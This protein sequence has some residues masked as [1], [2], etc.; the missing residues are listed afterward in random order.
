MGAGVTVLKLRRHGGRSH[1][2]APPVP[3]RVRLRWRVGDEL[4]EAELTA[5]CVGELLTLAVEAMSPPEPDVGGTEDT[6]PKRSASGGARGRPAAKE[7]LEV[8]CSGHEL[9]D[10]QENAALLPTVGRG[11]TEALVAWAVR[12]EERQSWSAAL[13]D[14]FVR[15]S[16]RVLRGAWWRAVAAGDCEECARLLARA[17]P[18]SHGETSD[19]EPGTPALLCLRDANR[20]TAL[21]VAVDCAD[22][23]LCRWLVGVSADTAAACGDGPAPLARCLARVSEAS[24]FERMARFFCLERGA[25][26]EAWASLVPAERCFRAAATGLAWLAEETLRREGLLER[27]AEVVRP[28]WRWTLL[29]DAAVGGSEAVASLVL[30]HAPEL[31]GAADIYRRTP[32]H[33]AA[34]EGHEALLPLLGGAEHA[35][36][37][38]SVDGL[39]RTPLWL[40]A[41]CGRAGCCTWLVARRCDPLRRDGGGTCAVWQAACAPAGLEQPPQTLPALVG[42]T[43]RLG[44]QWLLRDT[45]DNNGF[46]ILHAAAC[47]N[48]VPAMRWIAEHA[49]EGALAPLI[50]AR[51][52]GGATALRLAGLEGLLEAVTLLLSWGALDDSGTG[53]HFTAGSVRAWATLLGH[54]EVARVLWEGADEHSDAVCGA[55]RLL[56]S[57]VAVDHSELPNEEQPL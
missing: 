4:V 10:K 27:L 19:V 23:A 5:A 35:M 8:V 26:V 24:A 16:G 12:Q 44:V 21:G 51:T 11:S 30:A 28:A 9:R 50:A 36:A 48:A 45:A 38:D 55:R 14:I 40:A 13:A 41:E 57:T 34:Q 31:L 6:S 37:W 47:K 53:S 49:E 1:G 15:A 2:G 32:L 20:R 29:H 56:Y 22:E 18:R 39:G 46:T 3:A 52:V 43:G 25:V 42:I 54:T 7:H 17:E 33:Y